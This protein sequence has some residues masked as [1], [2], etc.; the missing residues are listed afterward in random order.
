MP[1]G[2][3]W[4]IPATQGLWPVRS[5]RM[6][7]A[8]VLRVFG[9]RESFLLV[10]DDLGAW[11]GAPSVCGW[12]GS[13]VNQHCRLRSEALLWDLGENGPGGASD[14]GASAGLL[15]G[16]SCLFSFSE[17]YGTRG[18]HWN[19]GGAALAPPPIDLSA[20]P[21]VAHFS[22]PALKTRLGFCFLLT[23]VNAGV[24][25]RPPRSDRRRYRH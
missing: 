11:G 7:R 4:C 25:A 3:V 15:A 12:V 19:M 24:I 8:S 13:T 23:G 18:C 20:V 1:L 10:L 14:L 16:R 21:A 17:C 5:C 9:L 2:V 22:L 6:V